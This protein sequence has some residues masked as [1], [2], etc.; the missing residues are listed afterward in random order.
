MY[1]LIYSVV[2]NYYGR[3]VG[4]KEGRK[5]SW[6][7]RRKKERTAGRKRRSEGGKKGR[8]ENMLCFRH[9]SNLVI[10]RSD[11]VHT[12]TKFD[13]LVLIIAFF[14][15][16][17]H[18]KILE[19]VTFNNWIPFHSMNTIF[20]VSI[21]LFKRLISFQVL[22]FTCSNKRTILAKKPHNNSDYF[23]RTDF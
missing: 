4:T 5:A 13:Y 6:R 22:T 17:K 9:L 3:K 2:Y 1:S 23:L 11:L 19:S 21:S 20:Y 10:N 12:I 15:R 7:E 16:I 18:Y 8:R 14:N